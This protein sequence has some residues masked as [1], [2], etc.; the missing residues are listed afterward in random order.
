MEARWAAY[1]DAQAGTQAELINMQA[2]MTSSAA[3]RSY[4]QWN[5]AEI[6]LYVQ[7]DA[8][9]ACR[10]ASGRY[11]IGAAPTIPIVGCA[12]DICRCDYLPIA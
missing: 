8:C 2:A 4:A 1:N 9:P 12:N 5:V 3:L 6:D 11:A 7:D 10:S